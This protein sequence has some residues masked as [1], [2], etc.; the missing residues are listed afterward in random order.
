DHTKRS[1]DICDINVK[2]YHR[3]ER[4]QGSSPLTI[5]MFYNPM[6]DGFLW[7]QISHWKNDSIPHWERAGLS[8]EAVDTQFTSLT[9]RNWNDFS[10]TPFALMVPATLIDD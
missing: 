7:T 3:I 6:E 9:L 1:S 4:S 10:T 5:T 2:F 8:H